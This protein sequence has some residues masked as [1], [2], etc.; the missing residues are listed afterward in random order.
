MKEITITCTWETTRTVEVD[1]DFVV[2]STLDG[3]PEDVLDEMRADDASAS[4]VDWR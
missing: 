2:P 3:F 1:D 4:L